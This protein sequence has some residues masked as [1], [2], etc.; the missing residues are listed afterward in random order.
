MPG[1]ADRVRHRSSNAQGCPRQ[2]GDATLNEL[3][4]NSGFDIP[5]EKTSASA[6]WSRK[7]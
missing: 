3:A 4:V 6:M 1:L 2:S 5:Q 7:A